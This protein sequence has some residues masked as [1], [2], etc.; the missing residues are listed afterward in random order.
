MMLR[1]VQWAAPTLLMAL[2]ALSPAWSQVSLREEKITLPT[3]PVGEADTNPRFY[4]TR[5]YQGAKGPVYPYPMLDQLSDTKEDREYTALI[6]EN[7]YVRFCVLPE[8]GGRLFEGYDKTDDYNFFYRQHVIKPDLIGMLGAWIS[9]GIEWCVFHHHRNTTFMPVDYCLAD[10]EDG[11]KTIW[12][13]ETERRHRMKWTLG[14]TLHP[15]DSALEVDVRLFNPTPYTNSFLYWANVAVHSTPGY[16]IIFPPSV[17]HATFHGKKE[18]SE[19]PIS[20]QVFNGMDYTAGVDVTWWKSHPKP[21]SFFAWA[22]QEDFFAGYDHDK[23]AGMVLLAN[24]HIAPG[25]K[26]WTWGTEST[27]DR[28]KLTDNDGPY[29]EL[30][31]GAYSDN[32]PDYSWI[33]PHEVKHFQQCW[34]PLRELDGVSNANRR[35]AVSLTVDQGKARLA[36]NTT[37]FHTGARAVL[38]RG[39][40]TLF[41]QAIDIGPAQPFHAE[42][43]LPEGTEKKELQA[44]LYAPDGAPLVAYAQAEYPEEPMPEPVTPPPAPEEVGTVEEL[45]LTGLRL[46][47]F[48]N[49]SVEPYPYFEEALKRDPGDIRVNTVL[50]IDNCKKGRFDDAEKQLRTALKRLTKDH[51]RPENGE[52][53]YYLGVALRGLGRDDEAYDAFYRATWNMAWTAPAYYALAELDCRNKDYPRALDHLR[54]AHEYDAMDSATRNLTCAVLRHLGESDA[55]RQQAQAVLGFDPLDF[56]AGNECYLANL[57]MKTTETG[58]ILEDL[59]I[60]M[61][62]DPH[63]YL[64]VAVSYANA[65]FYED[66]MEVLLRLTA[67][68]DAP[69]SAYPMLYYYLGYFAGQLGDAETGKDYFR[70]A[71]ALPDRYCFPYRLESIPVLKQA[72]ETNPSDAHAPHYLGNLLYD[73]QPEAAIGMWELAHQRDGAFAPALR[74]LG[75]AYDRV[76]GDTEQ[77]V[78]CYEQAV[79]GAPEDPRIFYELEQLYEKADTPARQR[80]A[81]L[82]AHQNTVAKRDDVLT[83]M[84]RL[85][86]QVGHYD[87]ALDILHTHH[88][89]AW[90][91]ATGTHDLYVEAHL[92]RGHSRLAAGDPQAARQDFVAALDYPENLGVDRPLHD[93]KVARTEYWL[94]TAC[95][96]LGDADEAR[97]HYE[98]AAAQDAG[99]TEFRFHKGQALMELGKEAEAVPLF[100]ALLADGKKQIEEGGSVDFFAK[101]GERQS[102]QAQLA[103]AHY[104]A[105]LGYLG[106]SNKEEA[107]GEF[108]KALENNSDHLWAR[109]YCDVLE[110]GGE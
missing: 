86:V 61:R 2:S 99:S 92:L 60:R 63:S 82:E 19:W 71:A 69:G 26:L 10:N 107:L 91:G 94:G 40:Q 22:P 58:E 4:E 100:E 38:M 25:M 87:Q 81:L 97:T 51:T 55:A 33:Q 46:Q 88:F 36:F 34:Y 68:A 5:A 57:D 67:N 3:Y 1:K 29:A 80:L 93:P 96:R 95:A 52:P 84:I 90:E 20:H 98:L 104:L 106:L 103:Q 48:Y 15:G 77:A 47:Q 45:Y 54:R 13:G 8:I 78:A 102:A 56:F 70:K 28:K 30:M 6:L 31:A 105:G 101:F 24:H 16:Q 65:G 66:A 9:G 109:V 27:A 23:Q 18:F 39:D 75:F 85:Q 44:V 72:L 89:D 83:R 79:A 21:S 110:A 50:A 7:E 37:S 32:Q 108:K 12:I 53:H 49:P 17:Q 59:K 74:N 43:A 73:L 76:R 14:L 62:D 41:S 35:A 64:E 11:S 42:A